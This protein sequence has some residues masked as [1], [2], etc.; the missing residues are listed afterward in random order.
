MAPFA[1]DFVAQVRARRR[2]GTSVGDARC[3]R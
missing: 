3:R 1:G 2:M